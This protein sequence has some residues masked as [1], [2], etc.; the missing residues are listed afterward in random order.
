[1]YR[2][3]LDTLTVVASYIS[4]SPCPGDCIIV[5]KYVR[6]I[7]KV[8]SYITGGDCDISYRCT[9]IC[10]SGCACIGRWRRGLTTDSDICRTRD[11]RLGDIMYRDYL[12]ALTEVARYI[13]CPPCP[14]DCIIVMK[15]VRWICKVSSYIT[16]ADC[17]ISYRCT[18]IC[19]RGCSRI[20]R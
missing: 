17:D 1:M 11:Y 6:R 9:V 7:C 16:G 10:C 14:G 18:I 20:G 13:G 12:Y 15:Y 8:S 3:G 2:D 5:I 4:C 19:C